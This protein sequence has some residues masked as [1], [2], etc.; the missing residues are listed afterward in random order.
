MTKE[1]DR[2]NKVK[3]A[4][5]ASRCPDINAGRL[6]CRQKSGIIVLKMIK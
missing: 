4:R 6:N 2:K 3:K 1:A 5:L